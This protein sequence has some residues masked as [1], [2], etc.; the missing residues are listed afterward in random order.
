MIGILFLLPVLT[1]SE[2]DMVKLN[3]SIEVHV[4]KRKMEKCIAELN[5]QR[6][7]LFNCRV[8]LELEKI[9][10]KRDVKILEIKAGKL[11]DRIYNFAFLAFIGFSFGLYAFRKQRDE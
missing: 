2:D 7:E 9:R 11:V 3:E 8:N 10:R 1:F 6:M 5:K 4:A